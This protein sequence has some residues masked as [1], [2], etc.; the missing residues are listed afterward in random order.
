VS[1][2]YYKQQ[3]KPKRIT[4]PKHPHEKEKQKE[5]KKENKRKKPTFTNNGG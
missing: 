2:S 1:E 3:T 4:I 5:R